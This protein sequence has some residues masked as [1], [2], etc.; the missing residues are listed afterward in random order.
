VYE[1]FQNHRTTPSG[2][3]VIQ[4]EEKERKN[5]FNS[6]HLVQTNLN[7]IQGLI[8]LKYR[9]LISSNI[10]NQKDKSSITTIIKNEKP[11]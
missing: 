2:R 6:R 3:K 1:K 10:K 7:V 11:I 4:A 9:I 5:A 8:I